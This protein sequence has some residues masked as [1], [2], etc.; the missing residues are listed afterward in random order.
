MK[1][2]FLLNLDVGAWGAAWRTVLGALL[3]LVVPVLSP[4]AG[5]AFAAACL[6]GVLF[7][8]KA[9]AAFGRRFVMAPQVRDRWARR[10]A[11][12]SNRDSYQWRKLVWFGAG[13]LA[14]SAVTGWAAA[15]QAPLGLACLGSG[16]AGELA[17]RRLPVPVDGPTRP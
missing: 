4:R 13:I 10:R 11:V 5:L 8:V 1:D 7:G 16:I 2:R 3:A 14:C 17:W 6:A 9:V 12:A 15:W